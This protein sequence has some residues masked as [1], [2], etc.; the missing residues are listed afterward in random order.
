MIL[1]TLGRIRSKATRTD[2]DAS[3]ASGM[4]TDTG[5]ESD[6][7]PERTS[8]ISTN[9]TSTSS[10]YPTSSTTSSPSSRSTKR[11]SNNLF[12]S[13]RLRDYPYLRS[14]SQ[15][16]GSHRSTV[17]ITQTD[18]SQSL[19]EATSLNSSDSGRPASP[20]GRGPDSSAPSS[21]SEKTPVAR[22]ASLISSVE[23][24]PPQAE[25]ATHTG[26]AQPPEGFSSASRQRAASA[27]L[28]QVIREIEEE[29]EAEVEDEIV[30]PRTTRTPRPA[31]DR[32]RVFTVESG[33][34]VRATMNSVFNLLTWVARTIH[35]L[36][37]T[38]RQ[39]MRQGPLYR[40]IDISLSSQVLNACRLFPQD[41]LAQ[42]H[43]RHVSQG[44]YLECLDP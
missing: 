4:F 19:Q 33:L 18:S 42:L 14:I 20:E 1:E 15:K 12:A 37:F 6:Y 41:A 16:S 26:N 44:T 9:T 27:A 36:T 3:N 23:D 22:S 29:A 39:S 17:S 34:L 30:M 8:H 13:G 24:M 10:V 21:P 5:V 11:Y 40:L 28:A 38:W 2:Q 32:E 31:A 43:Q 35:P 25:S 7:T